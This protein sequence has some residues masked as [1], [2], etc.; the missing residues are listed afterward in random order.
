MNGENIIIQSFSERSLK[1]FKKMVPNAKTCLLISGF[2]FD[3]FSDKRLE[4]LVTFVDYVSP[5][6]ILVTSDFVTTAHNLGLKILAWNMHHFH[7]YK[8]LHQ[9]GVDGVVTNIPTLSEASYYS[10]NTPVNRYKMNGTVNNS[11]QYNELLATFTFVTKEM[12][13]FLNSLK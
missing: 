6:E 5:P 7:E 4:A 1:L 2:E 3:G 13:N 9:L 10:E 11:I 8:R 12:L